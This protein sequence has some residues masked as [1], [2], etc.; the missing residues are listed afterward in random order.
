MKATEE[1]REAVEDAMDQTMTAAFGYR[2]LK[3]VMSAWSHRTS[4]L[5]TKK[6]S[7]WAANTH[8]QGK[9]VDKAWKAWKVA[10]EDT[11]REKVIE[12]QAC[13]LIIVIIII[14]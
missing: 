11:R 5:A 2:R 14:I 1:A 6:L 4:Q 3:F 13:T 12:F 9:C 7:V 10:L 8:W